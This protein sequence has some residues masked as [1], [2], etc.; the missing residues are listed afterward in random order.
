MGGAEPRTRSSATRP[1]RPRI[2]H[3]QSQSRAAAAA[4]FSGRGPVALAPLCRRLFR[5]LGRFLLSFS[6]NRSTAPTS[7]PLAR[8]LPSSGWLTAA[9][10]AS[11][12]ASRPLTGRVPAAVRR[13]PCLPGALVSVGCRRLHAIP[14]FSFISLLL[15]S[16]GLSPPCWR[17]LYSPVLLAP[18][19]RSSAPVCLPRLL[20]SSPHFPS[21]R[22][23]TLA[24]LFL[25]C[26][27]GGE[28]GS[29]FHVASFV[30][31]LPTISSPWVLGHHHFSS[32]FPSS[33]V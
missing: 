8:P 33:G 26:S 10:E 13:Q 22:L 27:W 32:P 23:P 30:C 6:R 14:G 5:Q 16:S 15:D 11:V 3:A 28:P 17:P 21:L 20:W 25:V 9:T 12:C 2:A 31:S 24:F 4:P 18:R 7:E 29:P 1:R 19:P